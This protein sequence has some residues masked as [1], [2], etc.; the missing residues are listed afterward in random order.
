M[1]TI[2]ER[3]EGL[4]TLFGTMKD[5]ACHF[6]VLCSI[7]DEY[8]L[9]HGYPAIDLINI[10]RVSQK[11][12][13]ITDDFYVQND[14]TPILSYLTGRKWTRKEV[15]KLPIIRDNDY[16]EAIWYNPRTT[17]HHYRRRYFDTLVNSKTV[18]EG[19]IEKYYIYTVED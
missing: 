15:V 14:G 13:W 2:Q 12:K 6:L 3:Y 19:R 10:I 1:L 11:R 8:L 16:T 7:A 17:Y 18:A 4:Q 5:E 9:S